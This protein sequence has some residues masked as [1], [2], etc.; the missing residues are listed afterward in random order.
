MRETR[1]TEPARIAPRIAARRTSGAPPIP[2]R[3]PVRER[4]ADLLLERLEEARR[5]HEDDRPE[6]VQRGVLRVAQLPGREDLEAVGG[7]AG[8]DQARAD[9]VRAFGQRTVLRGADQP[10]RSLCHPLDPRVPGDPGLYGPDVRECD[11]GE[12]DR[13]RLAL[14]FG[15]VS[16]RTLLILAALT[17]LAILGRV[18]SAGRRHGQS[19]RVIPR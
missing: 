3:A 10:L 12:P 18:R 1:P 2:M 7:D 11:A 6:A 8:D 4:P 9:G 17:G 5:D 16:T 19:E 13:G 15:G 14:P